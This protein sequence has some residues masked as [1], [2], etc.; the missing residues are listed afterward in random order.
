MSSQIKYNLVK[1]T[2]TPRESL[3]GVGT[4]RG[5]HKPPQKQQQQDAGEV[6][7]GELTHIHN[8]T[9]T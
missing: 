3:P 9:K 6:K 5:E 4:G 7:V 2:V 1:T 8:S